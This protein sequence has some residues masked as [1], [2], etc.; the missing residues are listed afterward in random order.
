MSNLVEL[1]L[2][3]FLSGHIYDYSSMSVS[4]SEKI[5]NSNGFKNALYSRCTLFRS[6]FKVFKQPN[7]SASKCSL[8]EVISS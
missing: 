5:D 4:Q 1:S 6:D 8:V 3:L 7:S 2:E